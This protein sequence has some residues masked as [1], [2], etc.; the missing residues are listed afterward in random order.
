ML[1]TQYTLFWANIEILCNFAYALYEIPHILSIRI[2]CIY[3]ILLACLQYLLK[4]LC[5]PAC[6]VFIY[7]EMLESQV[8]WTLAHFQFASPP[9]G[10][11]DHLAIWS[12]VGLAVPASP[13]LGH[14]PR[15][16]QRRRSK[17]NRNLPL[18][19]HIAGGAQQ[20][21]GEVGLHVHGILSIPVHR[22]T[23]LCQPPFPPLVK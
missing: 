22:V 15:Q 17:I 9:I 23:S 20:G 19:C 14:A 1:T 11:S 12:F 6:K 13:P 16:T 4:Y 5:M 10:G 3:W 7:R 18:R 8:H 21:T 2:D